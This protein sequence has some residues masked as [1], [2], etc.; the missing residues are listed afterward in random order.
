MNVLELH[1]VSKS[2][3][4]KRILYAVNLSCKTGDIIGMFG[5]N[6]SGKSTFLKIVFGLVKSSNSKLFVNAIPILNSIESLKI[7]YLPQHNFFSKKL[8]VFQIIDLFF[9]DAIKQLEI[10]R[11]DTLISTLLNKKIV[12]LSL[13]ELKYL[14]VFIICY[15]PHPFLLLDE[16]FSMIDPLQKERI[17]ALILKSSKTKGIIITDHYYEDVLQIS[18]R[19][20]LIKNSE[21]IKIEDSNDLK[22][23]AYLS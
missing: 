7:A 14:E 13:G 21:I 12:E 10:V 18:T 15:L 16:P 4:K 6:G 5:N 20:I 9:S 19:N 1:N 11:N 23:E 3:G 8:K 22:K 2:Y 17:K